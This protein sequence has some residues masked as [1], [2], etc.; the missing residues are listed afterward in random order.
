MTIALRSTRLPEFFHQSELN[1][2]QF[3]ANVEAIALWF[4][5]LLHKFGGK[6]RLGGK[7]GGK[8]FWW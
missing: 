6:I 2:S 4:A 8:I 1:F 5:G 3:F 7:I